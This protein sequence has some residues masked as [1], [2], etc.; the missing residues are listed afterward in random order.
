MFQSPTE[1]QQSI[2]DLKSSSLKNRAAA[3]NNQLKVEITKK[4]VVESQSSNVKRSP[5]KIDVGTEIAKQRSSPKTL[6]Q[7]LIQKKL[8]LIINQINE[9]R[10]DS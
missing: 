10:H 3:P 4:F 5:I 2:L 9:G 7:Q 6:R 8:K 1:K